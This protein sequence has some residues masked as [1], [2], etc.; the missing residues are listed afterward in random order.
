MFSH[1]MCCNSMFTLI[2]SSSGLNQKKCW[3]V[4]G[5]LKHLYLRIVYASDPNKNHE[6][7]FKHK[8]RIYTSIYSYIHIFTISSTLKCRQKEN[9]SE[10]YEKNCLKLIRK[11]TIMNE[12][13]LEN[14]LDIIIAITLY[15]IDALSYQSSFDF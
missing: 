4:V 14:S 3:T 8:V 11:W 13:H 7:K 1:I 9:L 12:I 10:G 2:I 6:L 5:I 15:S